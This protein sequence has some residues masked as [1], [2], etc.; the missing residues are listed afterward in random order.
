MTTGK[1]RPGRPRTLHRQDILAAA[2]AL[3]DDEGLQALTTRRLGTALG[4]T[5]MSLYRHFPNR[6]ALLADV[7]D[8]LAATVEFAPADGWTAM[9]R[10]FAEGYRAMLLRHPHAVALLA[11]HPLHPGRG[12]DLV[13][14]LL[15]GFAAAGIGDERA[16]TIVQSVAVFTLGHAL[17]QVGG[18]PPDPATTPY[19]DAWY[20]AGLG[21]MIHG[22]SIRQ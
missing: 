3:I 16:V 5:A 19:Y 8:C 20:E 1:R 21:A 12:R 9:L 14:P 10:A 7:V 18:E 6:E 4:V 15:T 2:V 11:T 17:A 13:A 22:F